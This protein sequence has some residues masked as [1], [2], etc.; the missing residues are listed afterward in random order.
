MVVFLYLYKFYSMTLRL[1][2]LFI[3]LFLLFLLLA[4]F[5]RKSKFFRCFNVH[6]LKLILYFPSHSSTLMSEFSHHY[7]FFK[8]AFD[9]QFVVGIHEEA[10]RQLADR[11]SI[12]CL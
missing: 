12:L 9:L 11:R 6:L 10:S 3:P 4:V 1:F 7:E 8:T 2:L 5:F